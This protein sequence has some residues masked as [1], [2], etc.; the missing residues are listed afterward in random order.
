VSID[1]GAYAAVTGAISFLRTE[2]SK[3]YY[4]L[5]FNAAD[6]PSA[7]GVA[8]YK[9]DD[10]TYTRYFNLRVAGASTDAEGIRSAIGMAAADLD[11]Q[12]DAIAAAGPASDAVVVA[13]LPIGAT[14]GWPQQLIINDAYL[15][16]TETAPKL[17]VK[18]IDDNILT[19]LGDKNFSDGDFVATLRLSPLTTTTR[20][21]DEPPAIIEV[22]SDDATPLIYD[23]ST[24]GAEFFWLQIPGT[25]T[26]TASVRTTYSAQFIM[27]WGGG[28]TYESTI[29]LGD[30]T[31]IH[32]NATPA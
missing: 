4:T 31:F 7:E 27:N 5:A 16:A 20:L 19:A 21:L 11:D 10:G 17:F 13:R 23:D 8:R 28:T 18:D 32:K 15:Q 3:H 25:K 30:V 29:N 9:L 12:L 2:S 24:P 22:T 1:Q 6:R 14:A 26:A